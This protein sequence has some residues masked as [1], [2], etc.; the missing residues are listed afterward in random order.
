MLFR[1][2]CDGTHCQSY[3]GKSAEFPATNAAVDA[4]KG[5]VIYH[6]GEPIE[7]VF[8]ASSGGFT[9]NSVD[10]WTA[11][12]PYLKAVPDVYEVD[13]NTWTKKITAAQLTNLASAKGDNIGQVTDMVISKVSLGGRIQELKLVGTKGTK[14]LTRDQVRTYF[15]SLSVSFPSKMFKIN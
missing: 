5:L 11:P 12:L 6:K 3:K 9:E 13:T 2:L 7:A 15:S 14:V 8:F 4:T 10:I 1:S